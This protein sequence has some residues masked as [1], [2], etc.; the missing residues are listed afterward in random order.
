MSKQTE[1]VPRQCVLI[2][3]ANSYIQIGQ[4]RNSVRKL[5]GSLLLLRSQMKTA[6][7]Q[8]QRFQR[9]GVDE[10]ILEEA[11]AEINELESRIQGL[12]NRLGEGSQHRT[13][14]AAE[15]DEFLKSRLK[16]QEI[17]RILVPRLI[18][19]KFESSCLNHGSHRSV[20]GKVDSARRPKLILFNR[21]QDVHAG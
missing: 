21:E 14:A 3:E 10:D 5:V 16:A 11:Q 19:R 6:K 13:L 12:Q 2:W 8:L 20:F 1:D 18:A 15:Q 9:D 7:N 4:Q 17:K